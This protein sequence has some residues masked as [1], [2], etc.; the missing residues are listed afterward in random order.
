MSNRIEDTFPFLARP[1]KLL[2]TACA[3]LA[4]IYSFYI[5]HFFDAASC[6]VLSGTK[7]P[8]FDSRVENINN[9][10]YLKYNDYLQHVALAEGN[11]FFLFASLMVRITHQWLTTT[12]FVSPN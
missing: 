12:D 3:S 1:A 4:L 9:A 8:G 11:R 6:V 2:T 5:L 10:I 7:G